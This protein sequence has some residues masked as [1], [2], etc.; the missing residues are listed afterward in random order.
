MTLDPR[1]DIDCEAQI[2]GPCSEGCERRDALEAKLAAL[3]SA[4]MAL[5]CD[6][7]GT[8]HLHGCEGP[9]L[10]PTCIYGLCADAAAA[11]RLA[12]EP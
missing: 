11:L 5:G 8:W 6:H 10:R 12:D 2:H 9:G 7:G 1:H 3:K 4:L